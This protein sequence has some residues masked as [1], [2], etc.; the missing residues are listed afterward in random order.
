MGNDK[1][2]KAM[3]RKEY[4]G[5][6]DKLHVELGPSSFSGI[7]ATVRYAGSPAIEISSGTFSLDVA[8]AKRLADRWRGLPAGLRAIEARGGRL[9]VGTLSLRGPL[10]V[11]NGWAFSSSGSFEAVALEH[12]NL[13]G[14][15]KVSGG[16]FQATQA[17]VTVSRAE[18]DL[19]DAS[20]TIDGSLED[21]GPAGL[22]LE[23]TAAGS[24]GAQTTGWLSRAVELPEALRHSLAGIR[25]IAG[26]L[27]GNLVLG[28]RESRRS[29]IVFISKA[30]LTGSHDEVPYPISIAEGRFRY[31]DGRVDLEAVGGAVGLSSFSGISASLSYAG[32]PEVEISSGTLSLDVAQEAQCPGTWSALATQVNRPAR[33]PR[34]GG[35][36]GRRRRSSEA[37]PHGYPKRDR[38]RQ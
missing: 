10:D 6:L 17:R 3:K 14:V 7:T 27:S 29:P 5:E 28:E 30:A 2:G 26:D 35:T 16:T 1:K 23:T 36:H 38:Q 4:E 32:S 15:M 34:A 22:G 33:G 11:P 25:H 37:E 20:L 12:A 24:I 8:Q 19:L 31:G 9:E 18:V 13:P 21:R